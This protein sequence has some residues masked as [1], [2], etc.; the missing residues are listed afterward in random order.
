[1]K[2]ILIL[3]ALMCGTSHA[4]GAPLSDVPGFV[5]TSDTARA[6]GT[7]STATTSQDSTF[8]K[9]SHDSLIGLTIHDTI[10]TVSIKAASVV[11]PKIKADS[12]T[13][14]TL[15][16]KNAR[17]RTGRY[18][19]V[20]ADTVKSIDTLHLK[21]AVNKFYYP[22]VEV[23]D[24]SVVG[25]WAVTGDVTVGETLK[26]NVRAPRTGTAIVSTAATDTVNKLIADSVVSGTVKSTAYN[27]TF[28]AFTGYNAVGGTGGGLYLNVAAPRDT[29]S[30]ITP[31]QTGRDTMSTRMISHLPTMLMGKTLTMDSIYLMYNKNAITDTINAFWTYADTGKGIVY[32]DT[33]YNLN[34]G[35]NGNAT[36]QL[37]DAPVTAVKNRVYNFVFHTRATAATTDIKFYGIRMVYRYL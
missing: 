10:A 31:S 27:E 26:A 23:H 29:G 22:V 19:T 34:A 16:E 32:A 11:T 18:K 30:Y 15:F 12:S 1:M 33:V 36:T 28:M 9:S 17:G 2:N 6:A 13:A 4:Q 8:L 5:P 20:Y 24:T 7:A 35:A 14:D 25:N 21:A 37:L 3:F